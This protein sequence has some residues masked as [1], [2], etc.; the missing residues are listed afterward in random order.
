VTDNSL[1]GYI[2]R[3]GNWVIEPNFKFAFSFSDND[4]AIAKSVNDLWGYI[5][6]DGEWVIEPK[7]G[8]HR[9]LDNFADNGLA[10]IIVKPFLRDLFNIP[11]LLH[12]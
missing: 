1:C 9:E 12:H 2:D 10:R 11:Q 7:F 6:K 3:S 8:N 5:N 4:L